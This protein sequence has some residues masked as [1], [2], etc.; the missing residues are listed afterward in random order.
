MALALGEL[1]RRLRRLRK[2]PLA[3]IFFEGHGNVL[4]LKKAGERSRIAGP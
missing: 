3:L 1:G 4:I 2:A